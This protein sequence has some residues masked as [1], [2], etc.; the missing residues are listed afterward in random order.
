MTLNQILNSVLSFL[1][2]AKLLILKF[3]YW[4]HSFH[5][6]ITLL[7]TWF[8]LWLFREY[9]RWNQGWLSEL[10][11]KKLSE[12]TK[13]KDAQPNK[14]E[15]NFIST[16]KITRLYLLGSLARINKYLSEHLT[17]D[18]RHLYLP[19]FA[20]F[21]VLLALF[22]LLFVIGHSNVP[23]QN[24]IR[25]KSW[26]AFVNQEIDANNLSTV[27]AILAGFV[28]IVF[29]LVIFIAGS[30]RDI[31]GQ[32][33]KRVLLGISGLWILAAFTS[34]SLLNFLWFR[35]TVFSLIFPLLIV[36]GIIYSFWRVIFAILDP[37]VLEKNRIQLL[38]DRIKRIIF[39]SIRERIGNSILLDKIGQDKEI[40]LEY[41]FSKTWLEQDVS[42]YL[43][44]PSRQDGWLFDINLFELDRLVKHL[45]TS[46]QQLGF[47]LYNTEPPLA[48][49]SA[50]SR[51]RQPQSQSGRVKKA[52]LLRRYGEY[53]PPSSIFTNDSKNVLAL[54]KE[55]NQDQNTVE[56]V[57]NLV[58]HIFRFIKTEPASNTFRRELQGTKDQLVAAIRSVSLG[59]I[60][61][62]KHTYLDIAETF[63]EALHQFGGG[64]S[65]EQAKKERGNIFEEWNE[66]RW[67][68]QD[69]RELIIVAADTD[70]R[71]V[72]SDIAYLPVAIANRALKAKDHFLFQSFVNFCPF[73]YYL[74]KDKQVG[75]MKS[76]MIDR[77]WRYL[78]DL[79]EYYIE[80]E[81]QG[82][83]G[84]K[85][86]EDLKDYKDFA[87]YI[88][89]VFQKL[90]KAAFDRNDIT[91][92]N[93]I[94]DEFSRLYRHF[95]PEKDH[96][97][98]KF[99]EKS[100][101]WTN[102][103][104]DKAEIVDKITYQRSKEEIA[105]QIK[106]AKEQ[107]FF[108]ITALV[109]E[110]YFQNQEDNTLKVFFN[111][112]I[113]RL[114][115]D[116]LRLTEVFDESRSFEAEDFWGW[117]DW[118]L[119]ADGEVH[120]IDVHSK[121]DRVYCIKALQILGIQSEEQIAKIKLPHSR[122]LAYL[123]EGTPG[124]N[125]LN[126][127][128]DTINSEP[129]KWDFILN[130]SQRIK[131]SALKIL[132]KQ[133]E[134]AQK[135]TEE[136]YIRESVIDADKFT[137]FKGKLHEAFAK[138]GRLRPIAITFNIY[139]DLTEH[140]P[141]T[142][143][144]SWGY[145]QIDE[146]AAFIKDWHVHYSGWGEQYGRGMA[147]S[148]DYQVFEKIVNGITDKKDIERREIIQEIE[149]VLAAKTFE[150]PVILQTVDYL[151]EYG[152]V[153]KSEAF[154]ARYNPD[155]PKTKLDDHDGYMGVLKFASGIVPVVNVFV[156]QQG[157]DNKL[158]IVEFNKLGFWNQYSPIDKP[159]DRIHQDGIF[160]LRVTDLN[161]DD[162]S[163]QK[164]LSETPQ[165][166]QQYQDKEGYLRKRVLVN[167]FQR[168]EFEIKD[169][170]AGYC[171]NITGPTIDADALLV[172]TADPL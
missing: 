129:E 120:T 67:L 38:K 75:E 66:I 4:Q 73:L 149:K 125:K 81:L 146:K 56:Y 148:E 78:K 5:I 57:R 23:Y 58:P 43:F 68:N 64:Y 166:L 76:F 135:T 19:S 62:L 161:R 99:L 30:V 92:F 112:I 152:Y 113:N 47:S 41:T 12:A 147:T 46:A 106:L 34:L 160:F 169:P 90:L 114:P 93:T 33:Q 141:D 28:S 119:I 85:D 54:P 20:S 70:N 140:T 40:K 88:F 7:I 170:S 25:F 171:L 136:E 154:T 71:D 150:H 126:D 1:A 39:E 55:F 11:E 21:S 131:I 36:S 84:E 121:L 29:A 168:L 100:L 162:E 16:F 17:Y 95:T 77:S 27:V 130:E 87:I 122:N 72:I 31:K 108:G 65:A 110:T 49:A 167:F 105:E 96:P 101:S 132:F 61:E 123:V 163:R 153:R 45:E 80:P 155:C 22:I 134:D 103:E 32:E 94:L 48:A 128:L 89:I 44:I 63:L 91:T 83:R 69:I 37:A 10:I 2:S 35:I 144:P 158:V 116:I 127:I 143:I 50:D 74:T 60:D 102:N 109:F 157:L 3:I 42:K 142:T 53:L 165:W 15:R 115:N 172:E 145:N 79:S 137:E 104:Q 111:S 18:L 133:L 24:T 6:V 164:I 124:A 86:I 151:F 98:A 82:R 138:S 9:H 156:R 59:S 139:K 26:I 107:V 118:E 117:R 13:R 14:Y 159:E 8:F 51:T 52:Y 97:N